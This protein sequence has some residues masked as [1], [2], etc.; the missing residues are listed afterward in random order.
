MNKKMD[1]R[2][3][4]KGYVCVLLLS[5]FEFPIPFPHS[6]VFAPPNGRRTGNGNGEMMASTS[7]FFVVVGTCRHV[8][9]FRR[10]FVPFPATKKNRWRT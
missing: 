3:N 5:P 4:R 2:T 6:F 9:A 10:A 1:V 8:C 7:I